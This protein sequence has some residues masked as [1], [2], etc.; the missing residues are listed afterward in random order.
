MFIYE[1]FV[2]DN[3]KLRLVLFRTSPHQHNPGKAK[4]HSAA[5]DM[6]QRILGTRKQEL[7]MNTQEEK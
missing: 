2:R 7:G 4:K 5:A 6:I 3:R 1:D